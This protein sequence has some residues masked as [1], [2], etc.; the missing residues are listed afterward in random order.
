L[1]IL[2]VAIFA[3]SASVALAFSTTEY[4][5]GA[6]GV[7]TLDESG[8]AANCHIWGLN[9]T[10]NLIG[11]QGNNQIIADGSCPAGS[12]NGDN[13]EYCEITQDSSDPGAMIR[14]GGGNN[15]IVGG[16]GPNNV[17]GGTGH[18]RFYPGPVENTYV[19]GAAGDVIRADQGHGTINLG[20]G[21]NFVLATSAGVY[22]ITCTGSQD[23]IV[24]EKWDKAK[25]CARVIV[26]GK[27][28]HHSR[29]QAGRRIG[30][31]RRTERARK[32]PR[33]R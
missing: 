31:A 20:T 12:V 22:R 11:C 6:A 3:V 1:L 15:L 25:H 21:P 27:H 2:T 13:D 28:G 16:G 5:Y 8:V 4:F 24:I 10:H 17:Y 23:R 19:G 14:G 30:G 7:S 18:N 29:T 32:S 26:I 33:S 9:L